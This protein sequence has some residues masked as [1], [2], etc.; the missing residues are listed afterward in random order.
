MF[1]MQRNQ[2]DSVPRIPEGV[3]FNSRT[4]HWLSERLTPPPRAGRGGVS[5][6]AGLLARDG[7]QGA[8]ERIGYAPQRVTADD[9]IE[10]VA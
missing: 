8:D 9:V 6:E 1:G 7:L 10:V 3:V 4:Q 2:N 5:P